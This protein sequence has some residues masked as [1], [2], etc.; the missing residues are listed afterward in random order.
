MFRSD[1]FNGTS[2]YKVNHAVP[3]THCCSFASHF[4]YP[5]RKTT[6]FNKV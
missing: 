1:V 3:A 6:F 5:E 4:P 2:S